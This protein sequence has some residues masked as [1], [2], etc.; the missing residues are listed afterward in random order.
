MSLTTSIDTNLLILLW[1]QDPAWNQRASS[2]IQ[3]A[4]KEGRLCICG[5][6]FSELM[7]LP[8]REPAQLQLL[9][10]ISG[11]EI[12]WEFSEADWQAA[13]LAFQGYVRRRKASGGGLARRILTDLL[14][15]AHASVRGHTLLTMD[16]DIYG[17]AFPGLRILSA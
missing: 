4:S 1:V 14:V 9:L 16:R 8:G 7:G 15:A 10:E 3:R 11:I 17:P 13:G 5:P 6:V 2:A 12:E